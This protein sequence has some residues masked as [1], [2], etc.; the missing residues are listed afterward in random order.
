V[1]ALASCLQGRA[2][3]HC[4]LPPRS[5]GNRA[6]RAD[7]SPGKVPATHCR[8]DAVVQVCKPASKRPY[9]VVPAYA[10]IRM[11]CAGYIFLG[12]AVI[13]A[14]F[15][16]CVCVCLCVYVG[17]A[18][19]WSCTFD[20]W[21][22]RSKACLASFIN[23]WPWLCASATCRHVWRVA[24]GVWWLVHACVCLCMLACVCLCMLV[25][26]GLEVFATV[27]CLLVFNL[28]PAPVFFASSGR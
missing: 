18:D 11:P 6:A 24:C 1:C 20:L 14:D 10:W 7:G 23:K 12:Q 8:V 13:C 19:P 21:G 25:F 4:V 26:L 27:V 2:D 16:V 28:L 9:V 5:A 17:D 3:A 22:R 15:R